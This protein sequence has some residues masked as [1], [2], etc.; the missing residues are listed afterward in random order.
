MLDRR[1]P[2]HRRS[3]RARIFRDRVHNRPQ[4]D[5]FRFPAYRLNLRIG[6]GLLPARPHARRGEQLDQIRALGFGSSDIFAQRL[7]LGAVF[8][9]I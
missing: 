8:C 3:L 7:R 9:V 2:C 5:R 1:A 4:S 6:H